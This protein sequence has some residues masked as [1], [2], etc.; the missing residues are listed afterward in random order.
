MI[1]G[2]LSNQ[3][4]NQGCDLNHFLWTAQL[5]KS[6][7]EAIIRAHLAYLGAGAQCITTSSYQASIPGF[8]AM[9]IKEDEAGQ[10]ILK[11]VD[12]A[13]IAIERF[14]ASHPDKKRPLIAA[15]IGPYG[16][17]LADGSEYR[18]QYGISDEELIDF[19]APRIEILDSSR[20]D[21]LAFETIPGFQETQVLSKILKKVKKKAWV[22]FSCRDDHHINDG[23]PIVKCIS[24]LNS[25]SSVFAVG[26]NCT[27]PRYITGLIRKIKTTCADKKIVVYPN[28][29]DVYNP[30]SKSW[31]RSSE[32]ETYTKV[33]E[34]WI[35]EGA[36]IVG[37]CCQVGPD[38]IK[39][40]ATV[41]RKYN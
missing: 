12:L 18:G 35:K 28:S 21:I 3:L 36:D 20:A 11:S 15:S 33:I 5:I 25:L 30:I 38:R 26:V 37:G 29:G 8:V 14:L 7:P 6:D 24:L 13:Q 39:D 40:A 4:A 10:L 16:A 31:I 27:K 22:S 19:H 41:L 2:G 1:D 17:Y 23:T 32:P 34:E 9:G